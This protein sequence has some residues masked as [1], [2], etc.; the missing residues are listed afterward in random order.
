MR[1]HTACYV[2]MR[3]SQLRIT[4]TCVAADSPERGDADE[5]G[6]EGLADYDADA[7]ELPQALLDSAAAYSGA[8]ALSREPDPAVLENLK[9]LHRLLV[10]RHLATLQ[11]WLHT[12]VK[13]GGRPLPQAPDS[14]ATSRHARGHVSVLGECDARAVLLPGGAG[15]T[16]DRVCATAQADVGEPGTE[17]HARREGMLKAAVDL[18]ARITAAQ[19]RYS[20]LVTLLDATAAPGEPRQVRTQL[21]CMPGPLIQHGP[22]CDKW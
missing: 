11:E 17:E 4:L 6:V 19:D 14:S 13:V 22:C 21:F 7:A 5:G 18:R 20:V 1:L 3:F 9:G 2:S 10:A 15:E 16:P 12:L 8:G